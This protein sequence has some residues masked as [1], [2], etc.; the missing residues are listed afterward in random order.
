[1][2]NTNINKT[3][4]IQTASIVEDNND[5]NEYDDEGSYG[6]TLAVAGAGVVLGVV[7][8]K[9]VFPAVGSAVNAARDGLVNFLTKDKEYTEVDKVEDDKS[10]ESENKKTK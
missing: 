10:E 6:A 5:I 3:E 9:W 1:M 2:D 4:D 8:H 7:L